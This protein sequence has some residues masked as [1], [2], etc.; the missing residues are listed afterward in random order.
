VRLWVALGLLLALAAGARASQELALPPVT[1]VTLANGLRLVVAE[2]HELP[3]IEIAA[4]VGAGAA[5]DPAGKEGLAQLVAGSIKRGA[6][7]LSAQSVAQAIEGLGGSV[8]F[9]AG[10]DGTTLTAEFLSNDFATGLDLVR[11][12]VLEPKFDGD[13]VRRA[14]DEQVAAITASFEDASAVAE[15][16]YAAFL[17]GGHPYGR[18]VEG[19]RATVARLGRGDVRDFYDRWYRP[20]DTILVLVG[21]VSSTEAVGRLSDAFGAW[22]PRADAVAVRTPPPPPL[23]ARRVLLVDKPDASQTQLRFGN[24]SIKRADPDFL[25]AQVANTILGG[26]FTS[27]LIE[28]L[29][30]R[31]SLTY[32]AW[33]TFAAR[34]MG[35]DFRVG[36]FSKSR[37]SVETLG[38]ALDVVGAFRTRAPD[39]K[40]L[41]RAKAYLRGQ[42]PLRVETPEALAA[43]LLDIEFQGLPQDELQT[44][45]ARV[46]AVTAADVARVAERDIP[47]PETVAVVVVGKAAEIRPA[48]ESKL[49]TVTV[50]QPDACEDPAAL[51]PR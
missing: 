40:A 28:E 32:A 33:S 12:I 45:R 5:Q 13:E 1:R 15:R 14:R 2:Y 51:V 48:L 4:I 31:R 6:G 19:R 47:A 24:M 36:T 34:L 39:P 38:L 10:S 37:T 46:A 30:I 44:Y 16:C 41:E 18:A 20:N 21:D 8:V 50:V 29:R 26:G 35:G 7:K 25:V 9:A 11:Q 49:G 43:R 22:K 17:Y 23:T 27:Q 42:F 3:L